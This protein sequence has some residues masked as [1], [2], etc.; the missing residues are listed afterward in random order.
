MIFPS[1]V[2]PVPVK[3]FEDWLQTLK[4]PVTLAQAA[5]WKESTIENGLEKAGIDEFQTGTVKEYLVEL[6]KTLDAPA[7]QPGKP[8]LLPLYFSGRGV[9]DEWILLL[10]LIFLF[11]LN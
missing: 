10:C 3:Q 8:P 2:L 5:R 7:P 1:S 11:F 6:K 9:G 4:P